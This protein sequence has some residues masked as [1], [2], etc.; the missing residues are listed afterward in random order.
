[1]RGAIAAMCPRRFHLSDLFARCSLLVL[2]DPLWPWSHAQKLSHH[3][4]AISI[5]E[6][7]DDA[8]EM[9]E[10]AA[11]GVSRGRFP[12]HEIWILDQF[13]RHRLA[14]DSCGS[15]GRT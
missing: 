7:V 12:C 13:V 5:H 15:R 14:P 10:V 11:D 1:V 3:G 9:D 2:L 6:D 8:D 4:S